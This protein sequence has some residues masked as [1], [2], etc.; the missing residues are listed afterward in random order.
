M[1]RHIQ[2]EQNKNINLKTGNQNV[3]LKDQR[4]SNFSLPDIHSSQRLIS[5]KTYPF[6]IS[7]LWLDGSTHQFWFKFLFNYSGSNLLL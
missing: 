2:R 3:Q 5:D 7:G 4:K 6:S 1:D